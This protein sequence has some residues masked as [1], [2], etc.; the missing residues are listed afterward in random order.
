MSHSSY[1]SYRT[2]KRLSWENKLRALSDID[3]EKK[4]EETSALVNL[5]SN[6]EPDTPRKSHY[7]NK[8]KLIKQIK[9]ERGQ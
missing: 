6:A 3:L 9:K 1:R 8:L 2:Y 5:F 4:R 7:S